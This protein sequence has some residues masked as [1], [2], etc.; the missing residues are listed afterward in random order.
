M[1]KIYDFERYDLTDDS[2][3]IG[4]T[5]LA[6]EAAQLINA[7]RKREGKPA[8]VIEYFSGVD[9]YFVAERAPCR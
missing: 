1:P 5:D 7:K 2:R 4:E 6:I 8:T 3:P 9:A